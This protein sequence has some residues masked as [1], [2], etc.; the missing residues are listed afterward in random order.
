MRKLL[1]TEEPELYPESLPRNGIALREVLGVPR[2]TRRADLQRLRMAPTMKRRAN[3][4]E[5]KDL[6]NY[7]K[8]SAML[9]KEAQSHPP[10][11]IP[12][13]AGKMGPI[14]KNKTN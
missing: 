3:V 2:R 10:R 9:G 8:S 6:F 5:V 14:Y 11:V 1:T 12:P 7:S 13:R 4:R